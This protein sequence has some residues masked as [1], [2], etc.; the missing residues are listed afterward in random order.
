MFPSF[1]ALKSCQEIS[2][3]SDCSYILVIFSAGVTRCIS[4]ERTTSDSYSSRSVF[5]S[6][7]G[8][9][10]PIL[11]T[12]LYA[13]GINI[14]ST[15]FAQNWCYFTLSSYLYLFFDHQ[16]HQ[17]HHS[18]WSPTLTARTLL[19]ARIS[20]EWPVIGPKGLV[21]QQVMFCNHCIDAH[22]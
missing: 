15:I 1:A 6:P 16:S 17:P 4:W 3:L 8:R 22:N 14:C 10:L 9:F 12:Y 5:Q 7:A 11:D 18:C 13:V 19:A 20:K 2:S 21:K